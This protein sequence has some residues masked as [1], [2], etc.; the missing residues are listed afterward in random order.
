MAEAR[1]EPVILPP[2]C[3]GRFHVPGGPYVIKLAGE[4]TGGSLAV[5]ESTFQPGEGAPPHLHRGHDETFHVVSGTFRLRCDDRVIEAGPGGFM[6]VPRTHPHSFTAIGD[7]PAT[8]L[9]TLTPA[10][11]E[12]FFIEAAALAASGR[13]DRR[14]MESFLATYDQ[15]LVDGEP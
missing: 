1:R 15:E 10:G 6:H 12:H 14:L 2:G 11:F 3:G 8:I 13:P 5:L 4:Q 9:V 7:T